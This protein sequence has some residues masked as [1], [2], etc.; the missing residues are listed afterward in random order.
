MCSYSVTIYY[1]I[2]EN[3][4]AHKFV[5]HSSEGKKMELDT[6]SVTTADTYKT[7]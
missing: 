5:V 1:G 6:F 3:S 7:F 2:W 4:E